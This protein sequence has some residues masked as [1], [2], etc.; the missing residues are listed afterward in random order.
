R[1]AASQAEVRARVMTDH[2]PGRGDP[3]DV[4]LVEPHAVAER[5]V[6]A[7]H[8]HAFDMTDGSGRG[9]TVRVLLLVRGLQQMYVHADAVL[10]RMILQPLEGLVR[11]PVEV[12]RRE[13][14]TD[15]VALVPALP[16]VDEESEIVSDRN[17]LG[18]EPLT[19]LG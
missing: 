7:E 12:R 15:A 16:Q 3:L 6:W 8:A 18:F 5:H 17:G 1:D 2:R 13:L 10:R 14:D 11:A 19:E 9:A 4:V